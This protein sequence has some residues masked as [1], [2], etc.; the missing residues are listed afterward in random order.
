MVEVNPLIVTKDGKLVALDAKIGID[1][2][3]LFRHP[4]MAALRDLSAP[5]GVVV[6]QVAD[7]GDGVGR[8][9]D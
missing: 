2:N 6:G 7:D 8:P 5:R 4:E 9:A 1:P 3:A